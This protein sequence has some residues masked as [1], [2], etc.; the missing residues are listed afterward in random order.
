MGINSFFYK[1]LKHR[2]SNSAAIDDKINSLRQDITQQNS[3][4]TGQALEIKNLTNEKTINDG[5][6]LQLTSDKN[7][8]SNLPLNSIL[9]KG[10]NIGLKSPYIKTYLN[11]KRKND[12]SVNNI[13]NLEEMIDTTKKKRTFK[14][15]KPKRG[16]KKYSDTST[17]STFYRDKP[18]FIVTKTK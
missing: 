9:Q 7:T 17:S 18:T 15:V 2:I 11:N 5:Q 6:I 12:K 3:D 10:Q 4:P 8:I 14:T 16:K 1:T 13:N